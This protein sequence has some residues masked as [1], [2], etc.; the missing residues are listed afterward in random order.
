MKG[1]Y[2]LRPIVH[3]SMA[4]YTVSYQESHYVV[5]GGI[6]EDSEITVCRCIIRPD[7]CFGFLSH[8]ENS[9]RKLSLGTF[10]GFHH[11]NVL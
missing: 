1:G 9:E 3:V 8:E 7:V 10:G 4:Y 11:S 2:E 5:G 6:Q